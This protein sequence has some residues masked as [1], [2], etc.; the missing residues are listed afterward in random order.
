VLHV[1]G[2]ALQ[3]RAA[4]AGGQAVLEGS[5][6]R[7]SAET[8][9]RLACDAAVVAITEGP[10]G[11]VLDV[12]R[13]TRTI[14]SAIRRALSARDQ[15]CRFPGCTSRRCDAHHIEHW[16]DGGSTRLDNLLL[17]CRRHHRMVHED[18]WTITPQGADNSLAFQRPRRVAR[19]PHQ[20]SW[21]E[22]SLA[23]HDGT[24]PDNGAAAA[25]VEQRRFAAHADG[26]TARGPGR[27]HRTAYGTGVGWHPAEPR[28]GHRRDAQLRSAE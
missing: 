25:C 7:V 10:D 3:T 20:A 17:L 15:Q 22:T 1:D 4:E 27:G 9:Q 6:V 12:G 26:Q 21:D 28:M 14:P 18:G 13:K 8:F 19:A 24:T 2:T 5:G 23:G 16:A 11:A